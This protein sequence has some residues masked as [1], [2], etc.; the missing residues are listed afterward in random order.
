MRLGSVAGISLPGVPRVPDSQGP[1]QTITGDLGQYA[2]AGHRVALRVGID[3]RPM[4]D[5]ELAHGLSIEQQHVI[6]LTEP[7]DGPADR[8][9]GGTDDVRAFDL[10]HARGA[11]GPGEGARAYE[12]SE[13]L[14]LWPREL[15]GV[16]NASNGAHFWR[17]DDHTCQN[18]AR[19]GAPSNFVCTG[20]KPVSCRPKLSLDSAPAS[21]EN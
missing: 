13:S 4:L 21:H 6:R 3:H 14:P 8:Q 20:D 5:L 19:Q 1:Q 16:G 15:F 18:G 2:G 12:W 11:K 10:P 17:H 7:R 9:R